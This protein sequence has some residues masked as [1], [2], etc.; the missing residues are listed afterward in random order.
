MFD[1]LP[2]F[3]YWAHQLLGSGKSIPAH[4]QVIV[5]GRQ[6]CWDLSPDKFRAAVRSCEQ[7][8]AQFPH[9]I[10]ALLAFANYCQGEYAL[11]FGEIDA[12]YART[13][14]TAETLL[15]IASGNAHSHYFYAL[16]CLFEGKYEECELAIAQSQAINS[17][18]SHLNNLTG[19]LYME[20]GQ[21]DKGA[22]FIQD[23][24]AIS[25][26]YPDWYHI[27][28]CL[29]HYREDRYLTAMQEAKKIKLK[30]LW[31]SM[32][33]AAL[34]QHTGGWK[35]SQH[36]YKQLV[37][38]CPDLVQ[39]SNR[40]TQGFTHKVNQVLRRVWTQIPRQYPDDP[41]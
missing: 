41:L 26:I 40:L 2:A 18:D 20:L 29:Y 36:E 21:W 16:S 25:P 35:K 4:Q 19:L 34:Y 8:L 1:P 6:Y 27:A 24:I 12:L 28:L 39:D 11:K 37:N 31:G 5:T 22:A 32:L 13:A 9:D 10:P 23:S 30:R 33:R 15:K 3:D 7:R 14:Q 38:E 17:L